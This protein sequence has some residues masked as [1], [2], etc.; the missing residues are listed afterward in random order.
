M[1]DVR[2][3]QLTTQFRADAET[4]QL[5]S[6][7]ARMGE[8]TLQ[9]DVVLPLSETGRLALDLN[10]QDLSL[11]QLT[12]LVWT[13]PEGLEASSTGR[14]TAN[15]PADV[16]QDLDELQL[17][18]QLDSLE[19]S[20][21]GR[22][23][24]DLTAIADKP[25]GKPLEWSVQGAALQGR[26]DGGGQFQPGEDAVPITRLR[27]DDA[28]LQ[29]FARLLPAGHTWLNDLV[30]GV[31][32]SLQRSEDIPEGTLAGNVVL[33]S[34]RAPAGLL[35]QRVEAQVRVSPEALVVSQVRGGL[36]GGRVQASMEWPFAARPGRITATLNQV[37]VADVLSAVDRE[38]SAQVAGMLNLRVSG[39]G[40]EVWRLSG[41][42][43][44]VR[45]EVFNL[46]NVDLTM[47]LTLQTSLR[48][49]RTTL[50]THQ[51]SM[52]LA[53]GRSRAN[54]SLTWDRFLSVNGS[55]DFSDLRLRQL[56][57]DARVGTRVADGW[58]SGNVQVSGHRIRSWNDLRGRF[59]VDLRRTEALTLPGLEALRPYLP[60]GASLSTQ[61]RQGRVEGSFQNGL[62]RVSRLELQSPQLAIFG[63]GSI[64]FGGRLDLDVTA[65]TAGG[66]EQPVLLAM[67][68]RW[69]TAVVNPFRQILLTND[70]LSNR[71][72]QLKVRGTLN[73][74]VIQVR[75][76]QLIGNEAARFIVRHAVGQA[77]SF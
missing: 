27:L 1:D 76:L 46:Q 17:N 8:G 74:P 75:P 7:Q 44:V 68:E 52:R 26:L 45:G 4:L 55:W 41:M 64:T 56:L 51:G 62:V 47:P 31:S 14:L 53:R 37:R 65:S 35:S 48:T 28:Q 77:A 20:M 38:L 49:G 59:A 2:L 54:L 63:N 43:E 6:L 32:I 15:G 30:G 34:L 72:V 50:T 60:G 12:G 40:R 24:A 19:V 18:A 58:I 71:T 5:N 11:A 29:S 10:W 39:S 73:R 25:S 69:G 21:R 36:A 33:T 13:L 16:W 57:A 67:L 66:L 42:A 23:V 9:G 3:D 70:L 61:F 22:A